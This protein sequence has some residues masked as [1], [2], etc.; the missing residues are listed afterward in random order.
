MQRHALALATLLA[1][2]IP[3]VSAVAQT[4]TTT[5]SI[6]CATLAQAAANGM[7]ARMAA[8][9]QTISQPTSVTQLS[10][11]NNFF[12]GIGLNLVTNL[13]NPGTLLQSVEGELCN[14]VTS[15]WNSWLGH[16]Q[17]G[18]T[19]T[20]FNFG[21]G[22]L[23]GGLSC[24]SLSFGGGGPPVANIGLGAGTAGS[25]SGLYINGN[26]LAPPG[27]TLPQTPTGSY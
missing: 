27:Y 18:L 8:D 20:G 21:F 25:G 4:T 14:A 22:G 26:G 10:C 12:S 23:G 11:L 17:C 9:G 2:A 15:T 3:A 5:G 6:G 24:P 16:V 7:T 19:I 13:L 1:A